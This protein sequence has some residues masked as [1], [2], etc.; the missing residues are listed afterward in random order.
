MRSSPVPAPL[1]VALAAALLLAC[2]VRAQEAPRAVPAPA[3]AE[4]VERIL[5]VVDER[6]LLLSEVRVLGTVLRLDQ[7]RALEKALDERLMY[8]EAARLPQADVSVEE[9]DRALAALIERRPEVGEKVPETELRRLL[10]RQLA[11]LKYVEFRFRPQLGVTDEEVRQAFEAEQ[12]GKEGAPP[13]GDRP[14]FEQAAPE[15]RARLERR[16]IDE[17]IES[18]VRDLRS[19][20]NVRYVPEDGSPPRR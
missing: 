14:S 4:L 17:R 1:A 18:W 16:A 5:A 13:V 19:R 3:K 2:A 15:L 10:R 11:I 12:T 9:E 8:Q 7:D 20:A 6:P